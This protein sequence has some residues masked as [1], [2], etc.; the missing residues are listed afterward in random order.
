[1]NQ[2][3]MERR[4]FDPLQNRV[5]DDIVDAI[6][7]PESQKSLGFGQSPI[8]VRGSGVFKLSDGSTGPML[9]DPKKLFE[10]FA[11]SM[12]ARIAMNNANRKMH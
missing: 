9:T 1:M 6:D 8:D 4:F 11:T 12:R 7:P 10:D 3:Y 5:V 2:N